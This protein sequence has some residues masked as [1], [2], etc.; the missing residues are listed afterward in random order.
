MISFLC[1]LESRSSKV[2]QYRKG[3]GRRSLVVDRLQGFEASKGNICND[4]RTARARDAVEVRVATSKQIKRMLSRH[5][6]GVEMAGAPAKQCL[7]SEQTRCSSD[8]VVRPLEKCPVESEAWNV[9]ARTPLQALQDLPRTWL[10]V[11][12]RLQANFYV[13]VA[14]R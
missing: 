11:N 12:E 10:H 8:G 4:R 3:G 6:R 1:S 14:G 7:V 13:L 2:L 5:R 9:V